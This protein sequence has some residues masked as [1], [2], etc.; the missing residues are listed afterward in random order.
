MSYCNN[1]YNLSDTPTLLIKNKITKAA[2]DLFSLKGQIYLG[3]FHSLV[4][5][6][7]HNLNICLV[8]LM[9]KTERIQIFIP[10]WIFIHTNQQKLCI[11]C[12]QRF[13]VLIIYK[14]KKQI[15]HF[16]A[17]VFFS[18]Y[19]HWN[20]PVFR[21]LTLVFCCSSLSALCSVSFSCLPSLRLS[22]FLSS[23]W[24][25]FIS[26]YFIFFHCFSFLS[27]LKNTFSLS[28]SLS[29]SLFRFS[30]F[31]FLNSCDTLRGRGRRGRG[32]GG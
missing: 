9:S 20:V 2:C 6:V 25:L 28:F 16:S 5:T 30:L 19:F 10:L 4:R 29:P 14:L 13:F 17:I 27:R 31:S 7:S 32:E 26:F 18:V 12:L 11:K 3:F 23:L 8:S 15:L 21:G 1:S 24:L 22:F